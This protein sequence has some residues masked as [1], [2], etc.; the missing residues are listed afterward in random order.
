MARIGLEANATPEQAEVFLQKIGELVEKLHDRR[1]HQSR[2]RGIDRDADTFARDVLALAAR[3]IPDHAD[4]PA[5][6]LAR[7]LAQRLREA[8]ADATQGNTL[9]EERLRDE[10][11]IRAAE[12]QLAAA[13]ICLKRLCDEA[14]CQDFDNLPEAERRSQRRIRLEEARA[15]CE[16]Q[17]LIAAA[18]TDLAAFCLQVEQSDPI[19]L[20]D[21]IQE[22]EAR[23]AIQEQELSHLDQT[24]GTERAELAR[25]DGSDRAAEAAEEIQTLLA[26]LHGDVAAM[27]PSSSRRP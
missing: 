9:A 7:E 24:I 18:G 21:A 11:T 6:E 17:L 5:R 13:R 2:I 16:D 20:D 12:G 8:Q 10:E 15:H 4:Q 27:R 1:A 19:S 3:L 22:L 25:M 14:G 23:I 26:G